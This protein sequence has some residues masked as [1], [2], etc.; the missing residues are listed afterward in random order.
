MRGAL[1]RPLSSNTG[2]SLI[3][4]L[5]AAII[6]GIAVTSIS[7]MFG[8]AGADIGKLGDERVCLQLAQEEMER[9]IGLPYDHEDLAE[10]GDSRRFTR[11]GSE[12]PADLYVSWDVTLVADPH[13]SG[14]DYKL[15]ILRLYDDR[16]DGEAWG[17]GD[18]PTVTPLERIATLATLKAP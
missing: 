8:T 5:F 6:L 1:L 2:L 10:G 16:L 4:V 12:G 13:G 17:P 18:P 11:P 7:Y 14:Q 15:I 3:E 9:L